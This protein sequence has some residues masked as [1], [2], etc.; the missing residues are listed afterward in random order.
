MK[1]PMLLLLCA[2]LAL[3]TAS[4]AAA[5]PEK[6]EADTLAAAPRSS[7]SMQFG[8]ELMSSYVCR[9][10][11]LAG[12]SFQPS[13]RFAWGGFYIGVWGSID[14]SGS[15]MR[16]VDLTLGYRVGRFDVSVTDYY[17]AP[18]NIEGRF[19]EWGGHGPHAIEA[20]VSYTVH[21][22][23]PIGLSWGTVIAGAD[24][25]NDGRRNFSSYVDISYPF[26]V[27]R[28]G[29]DCKTGV[30]FMP[31]STENCY[32]TRGFAVSNVYLHATKYWTLRGKMQLGLLTR[33]I[34]NP[35]REQFNFVGGVTLRI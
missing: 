31:W 11:Y 28:Y 1:K 20:I 8:T 13:A 19:F 7:F 2:G 29:V 32:D 33:F 12:P 30:G 23:V 35:Y 6:P 22:R 16:E 21:P 4:A 15:K 14:F 9:G 18:Q 34:C 5:N 3:C 24:I 10:K 27:R 17:I 25:G 26:T